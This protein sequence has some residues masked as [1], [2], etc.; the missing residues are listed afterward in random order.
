MS[1][2]HLS[3]LRTLFVGSSGALIMLLA[4]AAVALASGGGGVW[5]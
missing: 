5:P 4:S 3:S 1:L 2:T